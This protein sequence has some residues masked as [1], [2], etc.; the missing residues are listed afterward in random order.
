MKL[1]AWFALFVG[2]AANTFAAQYSVTDL[3]AYG[4]PYL[5]SAAVDINASGQIIG[6][7]SYTISGPGE[8]AIQT[9]SRGF[10]YGGQ[11]HDLAQLGTNTVLTGMNDLGQVVGIPQSG[12]VSGPFL[13]DPNKGIVDLNAVFVRS[14]D[15]LGL[16]AVYAINNSSQV[17][18]QGTRS[19]GFQAYLLDSRTGDITTIGTLGGSGSS[20]LGINN[21]G[22]VVGYAELPFD[23]IHR[24]SIRHAF[25]YDGTIHDLGILGEG[26]PGFGFSSASAVNEAG[27]AV[28]YSSIAQ[29]TGI[30]HAFLYDGIMHDLG[31]LLDQGQSFAVDINDH[32]EV[33][34]ISGQKPFFYDAMNAMVDLNSLIDPN[35]GW[36]LNSVSAINDAGQI[37]GAGSING[38]EHAFLM[39][40][41][42]EPCAVLHAAISIICFGAYCANSSMRKNIAKDGLV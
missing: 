33:V 1:A 10:L 20:A 9:I 13:Y 12:P 37:V 29:S 15:W 7:S 2:Y 40:P 19:V 18:A 34:G 8:T 3:G 6:N 36:Q 23:E 4:D 31:V 32:N 30:A 22:Q 26:S 28:G 16:H 24:T 5:A 27:V 21:Q 38:A 35:S 42:P 14:A 17:V 41:V 39:T 11:Y 25:L